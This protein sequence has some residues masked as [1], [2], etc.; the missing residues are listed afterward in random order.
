MYRC[1]L[2]VGVAI[3]AAPVVVV[4]VSLAPL[5]FKYIA[6]TKEVQ[7]IKSFNGDD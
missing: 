1:T 6:H 4:I 2:H 5:V 7:I 3:V